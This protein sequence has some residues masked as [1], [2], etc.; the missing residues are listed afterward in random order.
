MEWG[1]IRE[2][3]NSTAAPLTPGYTDTDVFPPRFTVRPSFRISRFRPLAPGSP[4]A[5]KEELDGQGGKVEKE[6]ESQGKTRL[7]GGREAGERECSS[8]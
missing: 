3:A 4:P 5:G 1:K 6:M 7:A 8:E 2:V